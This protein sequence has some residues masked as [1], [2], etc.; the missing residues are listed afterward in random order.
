[1]YAEN[2]LVYNGSQWQEV[3]DLCAVSPDV[4]GAILA[5]AL[6]IEA[7]HLRDLPRLVIA[8]NQR[9]ISR[10]PH[11]KCEEKQEGLHTVKASINEI[12][13]KKVVGAWAVISDSEQ[14]HQ[15]VELAMDVATDGNR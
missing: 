10:V 8:A 13:H 15:I 4:H 11:L 5:Q 6:I 3:H 12:A 7:V 9:D 2:L 14:L 1:M